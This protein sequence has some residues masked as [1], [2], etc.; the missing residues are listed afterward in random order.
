MTRNYFQRRKLDILWLQN[1]KMLLRIPF[2]ICLKPI[3]GVTWPR[4]P[5]RRCFQPTSRGSRRASRAAATAAWSTR[6]P[7]SW[8]G[9]RWRP[10][11]TGEY[12]CYYYCYYCCSYCYYYYYCCWK[13]TFPSGKNQDI[14]RK[15]WFI[16]WLLCVSFGYVHKQILN[17]KTILSASLI[18]FVTI[19]FW[20]MDLCWSGGCLEVVFGGFSKIFE[21]CNIQ[22]IINCSKYG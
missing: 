13:Y 10:N 6:R 22:K 17:S 9:T 8:A 3:H 16:L 14:I 20:G 7:W 12:H 19:E 18:F 4:R 2:F 5:W 11:L 21:N 15:R 1:F